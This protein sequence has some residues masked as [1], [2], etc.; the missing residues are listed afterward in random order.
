MAVWRLPRELVFPPVGDADP[1]GLLAVGGDLSPERL[2][3]AY[4]SG[5]F[6]WPIEGLP[7]PWF[8]PDPRWVIVPAQLHVPR[9]LARGLRSGRYEVRLD[10]AFAQVIRGCAAAPRPG[11]DGTWITAE[12][13]AA[14]ERLH[15]LGFAHSAEAFRGGE[16]VGGV[17]GV[18][19]GGAFV[20]ESMF[21]RAPDASKTALVTL[22]EQ[23]AA[24]EFTI[25][26]C[27]TH[28]PH[29]ERLGARP[30]RRERY[31]A[32]LAAALERPTRRG[33]WRL[34]PRPDATT[35]EGTARAI[36]RAR[37]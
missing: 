21:T 13:I 5:I 18:S 28:T 4:S 33:A 25:F 20:G 7:L 32:A 3:L 27:Q 30:W 17:Y 9:R 15:A 36:P 1:S 16:L 29:V 24:W 8:S 22:I 2:L 37:R 10:T 14:Y 26:D 35:R 34:D 6:P 11:Q 19:L 23:L 12:M 31:L